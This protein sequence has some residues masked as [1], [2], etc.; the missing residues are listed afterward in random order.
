MPTKTQ[1]IIILSL[2][3]L[4]LIIV[5]T[6]YFISSKPKKLPVETIVK[7]EFQ[8]TL[9]TVQT[10]TVALEE[11]NFKDNDKPI[12]FTEFSDAMD[13]KLDDSLDNNI[14][15]NYYSV[16]FCSKSQQ[17]RPAVGLK[18]NFKVAKTVSETAQ[19]YDQIE[20]SLRNWDADIFPDL[21]NIFFPGS[22][23]SSAIPEFQTTGYYGDYSYADI[24]YANFKDTAGNDL[25][26]DYTLLSEMIFI[27]NDKECLREMINNQI[28]GGE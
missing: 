20:S 5:I 26:I 22:E 3:G 10:K 23:F 21:K 24:R 1:K 16:F 15:N 19:N 11:I 8:N 9:N 28:P 25:S 4:F 17:E 27:S 13:I 14:D 12:T 6:V 7:E 2:I 18:L